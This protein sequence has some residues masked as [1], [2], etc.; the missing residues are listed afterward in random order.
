MSFDLYIFRHTHA[1]FEGVN[2]LVDNLKDTVTYKNPVYIEEATDGFFDCLT[3]V[4]YIYWEVAKVKMTLE[5]IGNMPRR[6]NA[7]D[8]WQFMQVSSNDLQC[9]DLI[10]LKNKRHRK[11][12][13]H[14]VFALGNDQIFHCSRTLGKARIE[15]LNK[16]FETYEQALSPDK[17]LRYIDPRD[18]EQ[19]KLASGLYI[20]N[21]LPHRKD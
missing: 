19:R 2:A 14:I 7:T 15:T 12:L 6:L 16:C 9:G 4:H 21:P 8:E 3:L 1:T 20:R 10:F 18:K 5:Y 17:A 13:G 11:L